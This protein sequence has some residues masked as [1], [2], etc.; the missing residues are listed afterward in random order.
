MGLGRKISN[1]GIGVL[2]S[3]SF[4]ACSSSSGDS[5]AT[6]IPPAEAALRYFEELAKDSRIGYEAAAALSVGSAKEYA[7]YQGEY[8]EAMNF[9]E[10]DGKTFKKGPLQTASIDASGRITIENTE[11][12]TTYSDFVLSFGKLIDFNVEGRPL[13][14][15]LMT[16]VPVMNCRT[17]DDNCNSPGSFDI[18]I[19]H[20]YIGSTGNLNITYSAQVGEKFPSVRAQKSS[21]GISKHIL[22]AAG[23][24]EVKANSSIETFSRGATRTNYVSFGPLSGGGAYSLTLK[25]NDFA[26]SEIALGNFLG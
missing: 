6:T 2:L 14:K 16:N 24:E 22:V 3:A 17:T 23:G 12:R 18:E 20:A 15:N 5:S 21:N 25:F 4:S 19:L 1:I 8:V 11:Y 13:S 9:A 10:S 26:F 7:L